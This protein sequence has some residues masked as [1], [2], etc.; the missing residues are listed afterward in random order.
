MLGGKYK[1]QKQGMGYTI[2]EVMIV[3]AVSGLMFVIAATF[4]NGKQ[5][6]TAF[7]QGVNEM[8]S[9]VQDVIEQVTDGNYSDIPLKCTGSPSGTTIGSDP[10]ETQG[11]N[12]SCVFIGKFFHFGVSG[13]PTNY[14]LFS[15]AA[16]FGSTSLG[17]DVT[18]I[19]GAVD[20]TQQQTTPQHLNVAWVKANGATTYGFGFVQS[21]GTKVSGDYTNG[22]QTIGLV[23][24][25]SLTGGA[26]ESTAASELKGHVASA[27]SAQICM[28]D[29]NRSAFITVGDTSNGGD[30]LA[31]NVKMRGTVPC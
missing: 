12:S 1:Q 10:T 9:R 16:F 5:E 4:I 31:V 11:T 28:T 27:S 8:A 25:P 18:P 29:G 7:T 30:Q 6:K 20:L 23:Y 2:I 13:T 15:L 21:Q 26:S 24:S 17:A 14:E 3:L 19:T 22:A